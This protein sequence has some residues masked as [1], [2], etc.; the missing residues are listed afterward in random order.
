MKREQVLEADATYTA[1][2]FISL[3]LPAYESPPQEVG[4][5]NGLD[6][7]SSQKLDRLTDW[8]EWNRFV[9]LSSEQA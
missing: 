6:S 8:M 1:H 9:S 7:A 4:R 2:N 5:L 3:I